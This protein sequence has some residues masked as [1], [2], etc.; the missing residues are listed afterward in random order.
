MKIL[1]IN[2][3]YGYVGGPERYLFN[4]KELLE[5]KGHSIVPFSIKYPL[6]EPSEYQEY[7]VSPL[8]DDESVYYKSQNWTFKS[9]FKTLERN[10]YSPEVERNLTKLIDDTKPDFAIVL[11]YLRKLS[12]SVLVALNKSK[13]PFFVRLSDFG[14]VCPGNIFFRG[15]EICE[16]CAGG[17]LLNSIKYKCVHNSYGASVVN[18]L[19]TMHHRHKSYFKLISHFV[20]PSRF[21]INK[22]VEAGWDRERFYHLPTFASIPAHTKTNQ[23]KRQIIYA[24]RLEHTKGVHVLLEA[25]KI[26]NERGTSVNLKLAGNGNDEYIARLKKYCTENNL[27]EVEF[28][29]NLGKEE[30]LLCYEES[31]F[32]VIPSLWYDNLPNT[33]LE[34]LSMGTPVIASAHGCFPE[35]IVDNKNGLLFEPGNPHSLADSI[36]VL[37]NDQSLLEAMRPYSVEFMRANYSSARHYEVLMS[38]IE[39]IINSK[40]L[41]N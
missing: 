29:G 39:K 13:I 14:M 9:F 33:A 34:S 12:P 21:L 26:L 22:M 37:L 10:F 1:L 35:L 3:R 17:N 15:K 24:G 36:K 38:L 16:L 11:L 19:A 6:N 41:K 8:S 23:R 40:T 2:I 25:L 32:S 27:T 30:L 18:Y 20:S 7:F 4:L 5:S 31:L 28:I